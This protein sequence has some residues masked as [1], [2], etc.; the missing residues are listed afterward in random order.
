MRI[1]KKIKP[2]KECEN[3]SDSEIRDLYEDYMEQF[4]EDLD[5]RCRD[6][7]NDENCINI[8]IYRKENNRFSNEKFFKIRSEKRAKLLKYEI[9]IL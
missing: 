3:L 4:E 6:I 8:D 5:I 2:V 7:N 1:I 9:N